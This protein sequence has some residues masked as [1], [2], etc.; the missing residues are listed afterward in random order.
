MRSKSPRMKFTDWTLESQIAGAT[1]F[2]YSKPY[3]SPEL[4]RNSHRKKPSRLNPLQTEP[5]KFKKTSATKQ[6]RANESEYPTISLANSKHFEGKK[7]ESLLMKLKENKIDN[8]DFN[9]LDLGKK[10][11]MMHTQKLLGKNSQNFQKRPPRTNLCR[12]RTNG[13]RKRGREAH[14]RNVPV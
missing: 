3:K 6:G 1:N 11:H 13:R 5:V 4:S 12:K 2:D 9:N 10:K 14:N 7:S 8:I